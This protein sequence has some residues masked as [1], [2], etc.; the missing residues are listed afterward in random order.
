MAITCR[1]VMAE[2][3]GVEDETA[4]F[5]LAHVKRGLEKAYRR[6]T[7]VTKRTIAM[8]AWADWLNRSSLSVPSPSS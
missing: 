6:G 2:E 1:D 8:Q 4:E 5:C 3:L 7:S